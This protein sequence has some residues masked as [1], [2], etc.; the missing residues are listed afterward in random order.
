MTRD[1]PQARAAGGSG[2]EPIQPGVW[3]RVPAKRQ[4]E[5]HPFLTSD[6]QPKWG[7]E[8]QTG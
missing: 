3:D 5:M 8:K 7:A 6:V 4:E 1:S 2:E